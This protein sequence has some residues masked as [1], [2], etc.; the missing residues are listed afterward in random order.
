[1]NYETKMFKPTS[2]SFD[3]P[4]AVE[5]KIFRYNKDVK[6][7]KVPIEVMIDKIKELIR[8]RE[9]PVV[10]PIAEE[11]SGKLIFHYWVAKIDPDA[12]NFDQNPND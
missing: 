6:D 10:D 5:Y 12:E 9:R 7:I 2:L 11:V 1:M 8:Q 4:A 3:N